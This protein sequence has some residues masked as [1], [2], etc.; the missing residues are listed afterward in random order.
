MLTRLSL[1]LGLT[2]LAACEIPL[3]CTEVGCQ[4]GLFVDLQPTQPLWDGTWRVAAEGDTLQAACS[5]T[6]VDGRIDERLDEEGCAML[7][8][9]SG[10]DG[11][12]L[13][14]MLTT[15]DPEVEL[16]IAHEGVELVHEVV[17][18]AYETIA[19]NGEACGPICT[20]ASVSVEIPLELDNP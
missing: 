10:D 3:M 7:Y 6:V 18:P 12:S 20:S 16:A 15:Q 17:E 14:W 11:I 13:D 19:P 5:F 4:D 8:E 2:G 1:I 9:V